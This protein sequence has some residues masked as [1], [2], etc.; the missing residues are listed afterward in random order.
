MPLRR[1]GVKAERLRRIGAL[2]GKIVTA[3]HSD[4]IVCY[5]R[6]FRGNVYTPLFAQG[7]LFLPES[8]RGK[9]ELIAMGCPLE[10]S[11]VHHMGVDLRRF[12]AA[13]RRNAEGRLTILTVARLVEKKG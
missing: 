5:P 13:S 6:L 8:A 12:S 1:H 7:D 2:R 9:D 4:D 3:F 11:R 10:R